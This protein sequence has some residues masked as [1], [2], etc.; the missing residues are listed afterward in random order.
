[1]G[2]HLEGLVAPSAVGTT[3]PP[4]NPHLIA[5]HQSKPE[6]AESPSPPSWESAL[7]FVEFV[8]NHVSALVKKIRHHLVQ[9]VLNFHVHEN[10]M[11]ILF[12]YGFPSSTCRG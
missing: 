12:K 7:N 4:G 2:L 6:M 8:E 1:M 10:H 3:I 11:V 5:T 9:R